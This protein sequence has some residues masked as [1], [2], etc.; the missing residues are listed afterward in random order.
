[1]IL[2]Y[3]TLLEL[4][5]GTSERKGQIIGDLSSYIEESDYLSHAS[6]ETRLVFNEN[7]LKGVYEFIQSYDENEDC[8]MYMVA[9]NEDE[10]IYDYADQEIDQFEDVIEIFPNL[11]ESRVDSITLDFK[12]STDQRQSGFT[13]SEE[14]I[15][16]E[17]AGKI[18][19]PIVNEIEDKSADDRDLAEISRLL[20]T[21]EKLAEST[22]A[23]LD[24]DDDS[25][26]AE[27]II[28]SS[29]SSLAIMHTLMS[30]ELDGIED[31]NVE[32]INRLILKDVASSQQ[33]ASYLASKR[34]LQ[35]F[36]EEVRTRKEEIETRYDRQMQEYID[37]MVEKLKAEYREKVPD[38]T[39]ENLQHFYQSIE[40]QYNAI[41]YDH[42]R[43]MS[44]LN[45]L[46]MKDFTSADRSPA[47]RALKKYLTL[48]EQ[49]RQSALRSIERL[50]TTE[51]TTKVENVPESHP[52]IN[53]EERRELELLRR[54]NSEY[55]ELNRQREQ[56]LQRLKDL[57]AQQAQ[58]EQQRLEEQER[59]LAARKDEE[60][61]VIETAEPIKD[62][63]NKLDELS[64]ES[65]SFDENLTSENHLEAVV[66]EEL[67]DQNQGELQVDEGSSDSENQE[68]QQVQV[69][70][71]NLDDLMEED[72]ANEESFNDEEI[73]DESKPRKGSNRRKK[74]SLPVKIA[75]AVAGL[76][77]SAAIVFTGVKMLNDHSSSK[78]DQVQTSASSQ[79]QQIED[80]IFNVGDVLTITGADGESL[81]VTIKEFKA[82]GSA[83]AE[84]SNK[85]KWLITRDQMSDYAK[86]HP[87]QFK[88]TQ[89]SS[90]T[91]QSSQGS[92]TKSETSS[93]A[94][95]T[96]DK[97]K[98]E[99]NHSS[100]SK[101]DKS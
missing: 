96:S 14:K 39:A 5:S 30:D 81:D 52:K 18:V 12:R 29:E 38:D 55:E 24:I 1:M 51:E 17:K 75:L 48:K 11:D 49:I 3:Y 4:E 22:S 45:D 47:M 19:K 44:E 89:S 79:S 26:M 35:S 62:D 85:D 63:S 93:E 95:T 42:D 83:V 92:Q 23:K 56:E 73:F 86:S 71:V 46:I 33:A 34:V 66:A 53:E 72:Q 21:M 28:S 69:A 65:Q 76:A 78:P 6:T 87:D 64:S 9:V 90:K 67:P 68:M 43:A 25:Q 101:S 88:K 15:S 97:S 32:Q 59:M 99:S 7:A 80:T 100:E 20:P 61:P 2:T 8:T 41:N 60:I 50:H 16:F 37:E 98:E 77:V 36:L 58:L 40:P 74:K 27:I 84:D 94:N 82:D 10:S 13:K 54:Q 70:A 57:E 91:S 31:L